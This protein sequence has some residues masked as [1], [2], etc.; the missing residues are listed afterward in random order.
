MWA[1]LLSLS[2]S[3]LVLAQETHRAT[4]RGEDESGPIHTMTVQQARKIAGPY[5]QQMVR[6]GEQALADSR[7]AERSASVNDVKAGAAKVFESV[8]G[9][10]PGGGEPALTHPGW[11]EQWQVTGAEFDSAFA[12]RLGT[13]KPRVTDPTKLGIAGRGRALRTA[14]RAIADDQRA[15]AASREQARHVMASLENVI[16][17]MEMH[18]GVT[19]GERQPRIDLTRAW[20]APA[21][22]W[23]STADTGWLFEAFSQAVNILKTDYQGDT[24]MAKRHAADMTRLIEKY[25]NGMD[26]NG[27]NVVEAAMMEGGLYAAYGL[28][29]QAGLA[30]R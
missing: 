1:L 22:Y 19:K 10:A 5:L 6:L 3:Q 18:D 24:A 26:A 8:W 2:G 11:K 7:A 28:A 12:A 25:L 9:M 23:N 20:E 21:E 14:L 17:L 16:G 15:T 29:D 13:K 4:G 30:A 27:N